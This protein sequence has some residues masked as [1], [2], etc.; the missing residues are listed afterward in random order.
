YFKK[1]IVVILKKLNKNNYIV[2]NIYKP[3]ALL[4]IINKVINTII[5]KKIINREVYR[6]YIKIYTNYS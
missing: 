2:L 6:I 4:N 1:S 3:I 5:I